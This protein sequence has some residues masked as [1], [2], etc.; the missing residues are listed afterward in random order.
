MG[1]NP[2][3]PSTTTLT[4]SRQ[5]IFSQNTTVVPHLQ[6]LSTWA[7]LVIVQR[8][9]ALANGF[10]HGPHQ[11]L[12]RRWHSRIPS[13]LCTVQSIIAVETAVMVV[14]KRMKAAPMQTVS[15]RTWT[16]KDMYTSLVPSRRRPKSPTSQAKANC[17][18]SLSRNS[19]IG[20]MK[21]LSKRASS[22][23]PNVRSSSTLVVCILIDI[24]H[25]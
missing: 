16:K 15:G 6:H 23:L 2:S 11:I 21:A 22:K 1:K 25:S 3:T 10:W 12:N 17:I 19:T 5:M 8:I 9:F 18:N 24:L 7:I 4:T 20:S 14:L 13:D